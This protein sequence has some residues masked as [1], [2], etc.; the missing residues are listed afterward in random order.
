ML[1]HPA[2]LKLFV[3]PAMLPMPQP[4]LAV[5]QARKPGTCA[6]GSPSTPT[7]TRVGACST[8]P[9]LLQSFLIVSGGEAESTYVAQPPVQVAAA[10]NC[11]SSP[12]CQAYS[13]LL[14][15]SE[16]LGFA[17]GLQSAHG[18]QMLAPEC[19]FVAAGGLQNVT[20]MFTF[21]VD[22]YLQPT[23]VPVAKLLETPPLGQHVQHSTCVCCRTPSCL[24]C[25]AALRS[26]SACSSTLLAAVLVSLT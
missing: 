11:C 23:G 20:S 14:A 1:R 5:M 7:G 24:P 13:Q 15:F 19:S 22:Q 4:G 6:T 18:P 3:S 25:R 10:S 26:C 21:L 16:A 2:L 12:A 8:F 17:G 9:F